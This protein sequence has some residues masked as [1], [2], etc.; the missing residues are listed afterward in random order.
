MPSLDELAIQA[1]E[2]L[3]QRHWMLAVAESCTGGWVAK[4]ITDVAG[5]S[6]W[7]D[8]G[9]VTYSNLAKEDMLGVSE[10]TLENGGAVSETTV[11][12]MAHGAMGNSQADVT[13]AISGIAGPGGGAPGKPVGAV[14]FAWLT[15]S[16]RQRSETRHFSGDRAAIRRKAVIHALEGLLDVLRPG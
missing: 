2:M 16:G 6:R 1:G 13:L 12:E 3:D 5:S 9:F 10:A 8:R 15:R 14:C 4:C 7:F 11:M